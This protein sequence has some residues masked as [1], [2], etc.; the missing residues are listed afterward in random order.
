MGAA[1]LGLKQIALGPLARLR[2]PFHPLSKHPF[3]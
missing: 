3:A 1:P 2:G